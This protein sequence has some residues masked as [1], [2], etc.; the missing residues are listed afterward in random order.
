MKRFILIIS[1]VLL[2]GSSYFKDISP[3]EEPPSL[4]LVVSDTVLN[5][6]AMPP[7][8]ESFAVGDVSFYLS[9]GSFFVRRKTEDGTYVFIY[10]PSQD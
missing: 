7:D 8:L 3:S 6:T 5:K 9:D 10:V 4:D 1:S 2:I